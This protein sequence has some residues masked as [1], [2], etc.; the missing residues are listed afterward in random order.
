ML[1]SDMLLKIEII[2]Y[3]QVVIVQSNMGTNDG[4]GL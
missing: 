3:V 4:L 1:L 2:Q